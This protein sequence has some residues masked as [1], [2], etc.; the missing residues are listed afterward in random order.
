[1][2]PHSALFSYGVAVLA[3]LIATLARLAVDPLVENRVPYATYYAALTAVAFFGNLGAAVATTIASAVIASYLFVAPRNEWSQSPGDLVSLLLFLSTALLI[4]LLTGRL[5]TIRQRLSQ[6]AA[7][8]ARHADTILKER[9]RLQAIISSIPGVVWEAWGEPDSENQNIDY[10]SDYVQTMV[11]Y[12]PQEWRSRPNLWLQLIPPEDRERAARVASEKFASGQAGENEFR[13]LTKDGR[14]IWVMARSS[15]IKDDSGRPIGMR[16]VTFDITDRKETER[17]L[18]LLADVSTTG[19][20]RASF[21][22]IA[23]RIAERT[24]EVL[25]DFCIIR[26]IEGE[27]LRCVAM[28]HRDPEAEPY[29]RA[30]AADPELPMTT[31]FYT[32]LLANP[33]TIVVE[34]VPVELNDRVA[35]LVSADVIEKFRARRGVLCPLA[36][37]GRVFGTMALGR[38]SGSKY[39]PDEVKL[40][41]AIAA[42]AALVL[43]NARLF[44]AAQREAEQASRARAAAEEAGRVKDEFLATLSHELRTPLNAILGWAHMLR[45]P[46]L[47]ED[48]RKAAVETIVRNA[49]SQEQLIADIL[50][51]QRIMA[52]K[53][54]LNLRRVDL[55]DIV[56]AAAETVQP[57]ADA[58]GIRLQLLLDLDVTPIWGDSD[59]LQQVIW[60]LLSNAIKFAPQGGRVRVR[61]AKNDASSELVV[62][63]NGPGIKPDFIPLMFE[64]F[65]QADSSTT[66]THKGL[67][68]G[69]AIVRSL[70]EMHGGTIEAGNVEREGQTGAC[71]T[72]RLPNQED[73]VSS[74]PDDDHP[75]SDRAPLWIGDAPSLAG[76]RVLV[77]EDDGDARDL[78]AAILQRCGAEVTIAASASEG[79]AALAD[80]RPDV[81]IS[82]IEMPH[83]DGFTF[84]RRVRALDADAGG[85]TPAAALTAY[86][87]ASD[88][89]KV[90]G[91]GFD[92][93]IPKPV[94]PAELASVVASLAAR[95]ERSAS[96]R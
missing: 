3:T 63:D 13:W 7:A 80:K 82:D 19:F 85:D 50:D 90:L 55:S 45:D 96:N 67:G 6:A 26:V 17:R 57:S 65:R 46:R 56:R 28:A 48:R 35:G 69:L 71:F 64:R 2:R 10:V 58:K 33:H 59:R 1:M 12:T 40:L 77:V 31:P 11:G 92:M 47:P 36:S 25:G 61:L 62:E 49:Q 30:L 15:V 78:V 41:E 18:E 74:T 52:G 88:R 79:F 91:A 73:R 38:F 54:R 95:R 84:I 5:N 44:E 51:V 43:D 16:G 27:T 86:A 76:I 94:Q 39:S 42:R 34:D 81:L 21:K 60:N 9:A 24:S 87:S 83:E 75:S 93:H 68:L 22:D 20:V 53:I 29:V 66:R 89:V 23:A 37:H 14:S 32:D 4:V 8:E 72:I 70:V